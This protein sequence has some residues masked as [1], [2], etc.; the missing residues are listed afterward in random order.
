MQMPQERVLHCIVCML[1]TPTPQPTISPHR[2]FEPT[3]N[4]RVNPANRDDTHRCL[5]T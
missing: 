5:W 4:V 2:R 1:G 3:H